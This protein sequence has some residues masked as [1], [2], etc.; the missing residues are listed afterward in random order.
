MNGK[1][2]HDYILK[3]HCERL[4]SFDLSPS[5]DRIPSVDLGGPR[6]STKNPEVL[7]RSKRFL[8]TCPMHLYAVSHAHARAK[9]LYTRCD[10]LTLYSASII[11][12]QHIKP[13]IPHLNARFRKHRLP[14]YIS[15]IT[16]HPS[17]PF[18]M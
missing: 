8:A 10:D 12:S 5:V 14:T 18:P 17:Q 16:A 9:R 7:A 2:T 4:Q 11:T 1:N 6:P 13:A 3:P 15:G